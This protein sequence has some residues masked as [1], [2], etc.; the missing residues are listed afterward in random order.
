MYNI[1]SHVLLI[2]LF[3]FGTS[4]LE[5]N[6]PIRHEGKQKQS[7]KLPQSPCDQFEIPN[8]D[9]YRI[10]NTP[11]IDGK[12]E[13][14]EWKLAPKSPNFRDLISGAETIHDTQAAVLWDD[15]YLYIAY[16]IEEPNL[17]ASITKRDGLIYQNNDVELFIAGQDGYYEFE[18]NSYGTIYEVFFL[19]EEAYKKGGYDTMKNLGLNEP[20]RRMFNGVGYRSHPR[21]PR[22][23]FWN[24]DLE[25]LKTAV[26]VD[27]TVNNDK[28]RDRGWTV[29]LALPWS[30]LA[31]LAKG[32][33]RS[34]PPQAKDIW[35]MDFSRF[36][37]YKEAEPA[38]DSGGWAWS[39]HGI[40]DSHVPECFTYINFSKADVSSL[41]K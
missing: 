28:D 32:D 22:I 11:T 27:G 34:V 19:W 36:N 26:S 33:N 20:G 38:K 17:Q 41:K 35:R 1:F 14:K 39:P 16:W 23:G 10:A 40:W 29:E 21:G 37:Q 6:K 3:T 8:Y 24:W 4:S 18:I 7:T 2:T 13:E 30:S 31:I 12:L 5:T 15:E 9:A 25:G